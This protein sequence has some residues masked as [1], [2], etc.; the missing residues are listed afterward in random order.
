M[1]AS[2]GS[3]R[4]DPA[5]AKSRS[6]HEL[7]AYLEPR[8]APG[9]VIIYTFP[10]PAPEVYVAGRW[11]IEI[12]PTAAGPT[13]DELMD[14]A[15]GIAAQYERIWLIPQWSPEWDESGM[16]EDVLDT[17]CERAAEFHVDSWSLVL[18]HTPSLY[19]QEIEPVDA[20][21][22]ERIR[23]LGYVLRDQEGAVVDRVRIAPGGSV[24]L[25][26]YWQALSSI[27]RDYVVFVHALDETGWV[28]GQQ[29]NQPRQ[30]TLPTRA[31]STG[32]VIVDSY[33]VPVAAEAPSGSYVI[34]LGLYRPAD[35]VR[36]PASG[37]DVD[38]EGRRVLI[39]G[40]VWVKE[41]DRWSN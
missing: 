36:L 40:R 5:Y 21:F 24:R 25:S 11:P 41:D 26:L 37:T 10:D 27:D 12:L 13:W 4:F 29:D 39:E 9:D 34:E 6:W 15:T 18:Y 8:L 23:L 3:Y 30:G 20:Y 16:V 31:W 7:F 2:F 22:G 17:V 32:D 35:V 1:G 28:R 14:R 33:R 19:M 38:A